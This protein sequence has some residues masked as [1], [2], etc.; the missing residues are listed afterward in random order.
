MDGRIGEKC[1][2][3]FLMTEL[4]EFEWNR[5]LAIVVEAEV[6]REFS[7]SIGDRNRAH[8]GEIVACDVEV[9]W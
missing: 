8:M 1:S 3:I 4:F 5:V 7:S 9:L 2:R 6:H